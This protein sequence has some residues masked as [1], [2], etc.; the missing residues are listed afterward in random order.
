[1]KRSL[2]RLSNQDIIIKVVSWGA[3]ILLIFSLVLLSYIS[4]VENFDISPS[5][6]NLTTYGLICVVLNISLWE[7]YF[8]SY[9][10]KI[11]AK[12]IHN[13]DYCVHKRYYEARK[14]WKYKDLQEH[15]RQYNKDF[16]VAW[17]RDIE[18]LTGRTEEQMVNG[19]YKKNSHKFLIWRL[20]HH[21]YPKTGI[22]TPNDV[23]YV[24]SVGR[25]NTMKIN[26]KESEKYHASHLARK[27]ITAVAGAFFAASVTYQFINGTWQDALLKLIIGVVLIVCSVFFG[28]MNGINSAKIKLSTAEIVSEKLEEW[29][30][31]PAKILPY[32]NNT[33]DSEKDSKEEKAKDEQ[34]F[35]EIV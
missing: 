6:K 19:R 15:I 20:K 34:K 32:E 14:D 8:K 16:L 30:N 28:S 25:S 11:M 7:S 26:I 29:R 10:G 17:K 23:L 12:D 18:D 5:L 27:I 13:K 4:F 2:N 33:N 35:L 1:M 3:R 9:Y 22:K 24:L 21:V 31:K